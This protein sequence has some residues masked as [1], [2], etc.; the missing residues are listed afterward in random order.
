MGLFNVL[1]N[2]VKAAVGYQQS[3]AELLDAK[4]VSRAL[5]M[6]YDH[7]IA[8]TKNLRDYEVSSHKI[9]ERKDRAVYDKN[10]NF[11]RWSKRWKIPIPYQP[12][13]NEIALVFLYGRPVN[14]GNFQRVRMKHLRITKI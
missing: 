9:M 11:L 5:T 2:Q 4:D 14:G 6:M 12:F 3:F 10:G 8:A 13:I 7:S 1:T